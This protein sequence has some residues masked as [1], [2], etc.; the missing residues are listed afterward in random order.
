MKHRPPR[1]FVYKEE[2]ENIFLF[3]QCV[4]E[5]TFD[6]SPD[7]YKS[8]ILDT[9]LLVKEA[10]KTYHY[11]CQSDSLKKYY[12]KYLSPILTELKQCLE[13]DDV[14]KA[15]LGNRYEKLLGVIEGLKES[16][17]EF[18]SVL[19]NLSNYFGGKKYYYEIVK[20]I[21]NAV[22]GEKNQGKIIK[23]SG[24]W[25]TEL[26]NLGYSKQHIYNVS[27]DFFAKKT[28]DSSGQ[29]RDFFELF[30]FQPKK[31]EIITFADKNL[32][33]YINAMGKIINAKPISFEKM[34]EEEV[35]TLFLKKEYKASNWFL[36]YFETLKKVEPLEMVKFYIYDLD[37]Y[38]A[39]EKM[40]NMLK[41]YMNIITNFDNQSKNIYSYVICLNYT[42]QRIK[43]QAAM[44]RRNR[45]YVQSYLPNTLKMLQTLRMSEKMM[46]TFMKVLTYHGDAI[47]KG[48]DNK[49][50]VTMLWTALETLFVDGNS[51]S[52]K[53][54]QVKE[55]LIAI[56]QRTYIVKRLKYLHDDFL[57]NVKLVK[58]EL[59]EKYNLEKFD[60]FVELLF[61]PA[62]SPRMIELQETLV[63]NPLLRTRIYCFVE[64]EVKNGQKI[65]KMLEA[66]QNKIEL[67]IERIYRVRN[68]LV[69]AGQ[70]FWYEELIVECLHNYVD[71]I[72]NYLLVKAEEGEFIYS[73][74][75]V[76]SE[77]K[78]DNE[79]HSSVLR[80]NK[81]MKI[82]GDNYL[83]LLFGASDNVLKY[84]EEHIV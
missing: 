1:S 36:Q 22:Q 65:E 61:D 77:A 39:V 24:V 64:K 63:Q 49:Y 44:E 55:A 14:A 35:K 31:W 19:H 71:F 8:P 37:P 42:K 68:F 70:S 76:V 60:I 17:Y 32:V 18:E 78:I 84:Y 56:I 40:Y 73:I 33:P 27:N 12:S 58:K 29:I 23:L 59:I 13:L 6:Y 80:K 69:H 21:E 82:V 2:T 53:G 11:L 50:V 62:D 41:V 83:K 66:H 72:I 67:Q 28:I 52:A 38:K 25:V 45:K 10:L 54:S 9:R 46:D 48:L 30:T 75:D 57:N 74:R 3:Y 4:N 43:M 15:L 16:D 5:M 47:C 26:L 20:Q 79:I 7:T 81:E 51:G 34:S